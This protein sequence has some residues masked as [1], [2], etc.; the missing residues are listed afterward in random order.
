M[1]PGKQKYKK[2]SYLELHRLQLKNIFMHKSKTTIWGQYLLQKLASKKLIVY[3][4]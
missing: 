3:N 1:T 4:I 2:N